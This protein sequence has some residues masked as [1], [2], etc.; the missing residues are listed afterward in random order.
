M[1]EMNEKNEM[2]EN[3]EKDAGE[4][5]DGYEK[6]VEKVGGR[7]AVIQ[8]LGDVTVKLSKPVMLKGKEVTEL[9]MDFLSMTGLDM[10]LIDDKIGATELRGLLPAYSRKYQRILAARAANVPDELILKL[11]MADYSVVVGAARNFLLVTG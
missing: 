4:L 7:E 8:R 3:E 11:P 10:E 2:L 5:L 6:A 1:A 9:H